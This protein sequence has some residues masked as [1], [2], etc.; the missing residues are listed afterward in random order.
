M[1]SYYTR[2]H[3]K[4]KLRRTED[5]K[6]TERCLESTEMAAAELLELVY[7]I[8]VVFRLNP[9]STGARNP[10]LYSLSI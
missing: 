8:M 4:P 5:M 10:L 6:S 1:M 2:Q 9:I 7:Y 3:F